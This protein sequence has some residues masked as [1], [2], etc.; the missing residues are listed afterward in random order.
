MKR[1]GFVLL[2]ALVQTRAGG[3]TKGDG[4]WVI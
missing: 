2:L 3:Y 4:S 1:S